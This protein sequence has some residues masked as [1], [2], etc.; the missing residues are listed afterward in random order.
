MTDEMLMERVVKGELQALGTLFERCKQPLFGFLLRILHDQAQAEDVLVDT[1]LRVQDR[2]ATYK[3]GMKFTTWLYT[4]AYHLATD[5]LRRTARHEQLE[6]QLAREEV[7]SSH[8]PI[9]EACERA[10]LADAVRQ[11][12][13]SLPEEQRT[14][15]LLREYEGFSYREIAEVTGGTEEAVRVRAHRARLALRARLSPYLQG[16]AEAGVTFAAT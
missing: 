11:A 8:D 13:N 1:F 2:R 12:V 10:E 14:V 7:S 3:S 9:H 4:I 15:I 6:Q 5:R 16:D